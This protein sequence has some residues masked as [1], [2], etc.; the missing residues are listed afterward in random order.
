V[1]FL[2]FGEVQVRA[3]GQSLDVGTRRQQAVLA[4]LAVDA[5]R[6]VTIEALVDRVWNDTP[7]AE[8]RNV[9]YSHVSRIRRMLR[10]GAGA[11]EVAPRIERRLAGYALDVDPDRV[12]L[13]RF[14]RLADRGLD[15]RCTDA[16][17]ASLLGA[18]LQL[19]S[20][21]APLGGV[22]GAW[23][24]QVR[25]S[26]HRRRLATVVGWALAELRLGRP[27]LVISPLADL[28]AEH[29]LAE[30][31][32]EAL[33]RALH[34]AG[35]SAEAIERYAALR[36]RLA[37][38]LGVDP[39]SELQTLH[40]ALLRGALPVAVSPAPVPDNDPSPA[41]LPPDVL[42]FA[43][44][45][46]ELRRLD[47]VA[48]ADERGTA[49]I[50]ITGTAGVGKTALAVHW[51]HRTRERFP[52]GQLYVNLRG[53]DPTGSPLNPA[54][55]VRG[56]LDALEVRPERI[57]ASFEA[58]VGLYRS[59]LAQRRTLVLL[60]NARDAEQVRPLLP[61]A[62]GSAVVVTSRD[63]L[64]SLVADG[65]HPVTLGLLDGAEARELLAYRIGAARVVAEPAAV[66]KILSLCARLPLALSV[67]AA[68]AALHPG[69]PLA[70]LAGELAGPQMWPVPAGQE[71]DARAVLPSFAG[72]G[73]QTDPRAV[74][75]WS[76]RQLSEAAAGVFR[77]LGLHPG[78]DVTVPAAA[79]L[80]ARPVAEM[81]PLL[82]E[83]AR[84]HLV[85]EHTLGRYTSHDLLRAYAA[86]LAES[87][88]GD[89]QRHA[90]SRR[91]LAYYVHTS[92]AADALIDPHRDAA[93]SVPAM[94][95]GVVAESLTGREQA[96]AW[97]AAERP[98]LITVLRRSAGFDAEGWHL[99]WALRRFLAYHCHWQDE[100]VALTLGLAAAQRMG[101]L[102][103]EAF[104]YC[105]LGC[106]QA[107]FGRFD[108]ARGH[109]QSALD[110]YRD[111][112]DPVGQAR[113]HH[114]FAWMLEQQGRDHEALAHAQAE[115]DLYRAVGHLVGQAKALNAVGWFH[116][117]L[118][119]HERAV[120]HCQRALRLQRDLGDRLG[121]AGT[122]DSLG[123][124][125]H[126]LDQ[127]AWAFTHYRA[128][129][130][131]YRELGHRY[132][133][134][135]VLNSLGDAYQATGDTPAAA[136]AWQAAHDLWSDLG[137]VNLD[138]VRAK[139]A[140]LSALDAGA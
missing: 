116:S 81:R 32:E 98:V 46:R 140:R 63:Q 35:R 110:R 52:D 130:T 100:V 134:A 124:A 40:E 71:D 53:F 43:G 112:G 70:A 64:T 1:E 22:P 114:L 102:G 132:H 84:A 26:W 86:E 60:D 28:A 85:E 18:A 128:A 119:D 61:G 89:D 31:L 33:M 77:L 106:A 57:P 3:G 125:H 48:V 113:V 36:R 38:H 103:R 109:L 118:G 74:F 29:P 11:G 92:D 115:L 97:L 120:E 105:Y 66:E 83:L 65:A 54:E 75:S 137:T 27:E 126:R 76:Y 62:S 9:V 34:A 12:D 72:A 37:D 82:A 136:A 131:L 104:A 39:G 139:L 129:A 21:G 101:D 135:D 123:Y 6:P 2:L 93:P 13:I 5:P 90:A 20:R 7:P 16:D 41:Q 91:V 4:A 25:D 94:P 79:S 117:R 14:T 15:P 69:F 58:Q 80:A 17:R 73:P 44:R 96:L 24:D 111:V 50:T 133:E 30:S 45:D 138:H 67:V 78:S 87:L 127:H 49:L 55:A 107:H 56:F 47:R 95:A 121:E 8:A 122:L 108:I 10:H 88:D 19:L 23:A 51:A 42:V 99:A 68:R 59:L